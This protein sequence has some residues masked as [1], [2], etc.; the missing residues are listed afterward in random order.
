MRLRRVVL[1]GFKT[2]ADRTVVQFEPGITGIVGANGS[3]KSNLVDAIRWAL[4]ETSARELRGSRLD[5]MIFAGGQGRGRMGFADV[6]LV[7][8]NE[9]GRLPVDDAEVGLSRR[10]VRD[11]DIEYRLNGQRV[12]LRDLERLL[13]GTGLTQH[14]YAVVA[15]QDIEA[16]IEASPRQRRALVEQAAGVR[17]VRSAGDDAMRRLEQVDAVV[18]RLAERLGEAE[19]R[20]AALA[21]ELGAALELRALSDRLAELRGSLAR[22][23]WRAARARARQARRR[24]EAAERRL[25]GSREA[26]EAFA[27]RVEEGRLQLEAARDRERRSADLLEAARMASERSLGESRRFAERARGAVLHRADAC[28]QLGSALAEV[29]AVEAALAGLDRADGAS[30]ELSAL[31]AEAAELEAGVALRDQELGEAAAAVAHAERAAAAGTAE[32]A[33]AEGAARQRAADR[34]AADRLLSAADAQQ[35]A[36]ERRCSGLDAALGPARDRHAAVA[37]ELRR[38][39][40]ESSDLSASLDALREARG[41]AEARLLEERERASA[42]V[43]RAAELRGQLAGALGG[44]GAVAQ[45]AAEVG[46]VRLVNSLRVLDPRDGTA[47]EAALEGHL[48]AWVVEDLGAAV[49]LLGDSAV[50]EEIFAAGSGTE[51]PRAEVDSAVAAPEGARSALSA[52]AVPP[53]ARGAAAHCL[54][55]AWLVADLATAR[56]LV[57]MVGGRAVLPGGMVVTRA[58]VRGGGRPQALALAAAARAAGLEAEGAQAAEQDAQAEVHR[59][60]AAAASRE[61]GLRAAEERLAGVRTREAEARA[62]GTALETARESEARR[63]AEL[64]TEVSRLGEAAARAGAAAE[65]AAGAVETARAASSA[66]LEALRMERS[67]HAAARGTYEE[68]AAQV[69]GVR[70]RL[71]ELRRQAEEAR[72]LRGEAA[73]RHQAAGLRLAEVQG[74]VASAETDILTALAHGLAAG[75]EAGSAAER[76]AVLERAVAAAAAPRSEAEARLTALE[77][78]RAEIRVAVARA[79]DEVAAARQEA[80][81]AEAHLAEQAEA[82]RGEVEEEEVELD[83]AAAERAEREIARLERRIGAMGPVNALAPE[84]H[85]SLEAHVLRLRG[86]RDDLAAAARDVRHLAHRLGVEASRRFDAVFGAVGAHF[87]DL[88]CELFGGGRATL[89]LEDPP[90][91]SLPRG[92]EEPAAAGDA[93]SADG[94]TGEDLRGV[95]ILAQPPGKRL[96]PLTH[97]S[98]GERALTALAMVLALQQVSPSPFYIFDEVD[99]PL[100]DASV[101]RFTRLLTR[102]A[103]EQQFILVTHNHLTMAAADALY[104]VTADREGVSSVVSVRF[105]DHDESLETVGLLQVPLRR[106]AS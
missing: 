65:V 28:V 82:L 55:G 102:L 12:R 68:A 59:L 74:R 99:A 95:E 52:I 15:Q 75:R 81:T 53:R 87:T 46:A 89:R 72:R 78:E 51:E 32:A 34:E 10:V 38:A 16:I 27:R 24:L 66:A 19:P 56:R 8:D 88:F 105:P 44:E 23:E 79:E 80:E 25:E 30:E 57:E 98:G 77:G 58:G 73:A 35:A 97:L 36:A 13:S 26:E 33:Q 7:I 47:I 17:S 9:D 91:L 92:D 45:R 39:L 31:E 29:E 60:A 104:G 54:E 2:F 100:D 61:A 84:Q 63:V 21:A 62:A 40:T 6:E 5:E 22:E 3:G 50:R 18:L 96:Q 94:A 37:A 67:R 42:A 11:G 90:A 71:D 70:R 48:G 86:Q 76:V 14:G 101:G 4:G 103:A 83:P 106:A 49:A 1:N 69:G 20:L 93:G 41:K 43:R 85:S 64:G